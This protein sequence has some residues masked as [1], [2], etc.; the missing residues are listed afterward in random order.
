M[1]NNKGGYVFESNGKWY[2]RVT[3]RGDDG[4]VRNIKRT[5]KSQTEAKNILKKLV[6]KIDDEGVQVIDTEKYTFNDLADY[7]TT[8]YIKEPEYFNGR[9]V[10]GL[11]DWLRRKNMV[12]MICGHFGHRKLRE[13]NFGDLLS[14]RSLRLKTKTKQK[15]QR[16]ITTVNRE[17]AC[18]RRMFNIALRQ[19]WVNKNPFNCGESLIEISAERRREKIL[20]ME[21]ERRLIAACE[22]PQRKHL[23]PLLIAL[24]DTGARKGEALKLTWQDVDFENGLITFQAL[25]TKTLRTRQVAITSRLRA[26]LE[27]LWENSDKKI[28]SIVFGII[29]NVSK[30]FAS[31]CKE[32][33]IETGGIYGLTLHCLRHSAATRLVKGQM[34]IQMVGRILGHTQPQTTYRYL[35]AN[36]ETLHQAANIL[37]SIQSL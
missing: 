19:G 1:A 17:L 36:E 5:A 24:L 13:I 16:T 12:K 29:D 26:E 11:R 14:F 9:K 20:T 4:K 31:A 2:A 7:Y 37:E 6:R 8:Y 34:P 3:E 10:S 21:E 30:S 23:K 27:N 28:D 15:K 22:H 25:N 33:K 18:L 32:A 35:S